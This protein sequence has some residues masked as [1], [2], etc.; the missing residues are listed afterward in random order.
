MTGG[1]K[2]EKSLFELIQVAVGNRS[3]LSS[4]PTQ[5]EWQQLYGLL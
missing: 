5:D 2:I 4:V 3:S 1:N